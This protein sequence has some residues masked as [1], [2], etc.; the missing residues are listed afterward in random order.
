MIAVRLIAFCAAVIISG[1]QFDT[2]GAPL[3]EGTGIDASVSGADAVPLASDALVAP[4][5]FSAPD[6]LVADECPVECDDGEICVQGECRRMRPARNC[7]MC[8]CESCEDM[9]R[10]CCT[11]DGEPMCVDGDFCPS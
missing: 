3:E 4:D 6:A 11:I 2:S 10:S 7:D 8:P 5:A 9:G 1:C